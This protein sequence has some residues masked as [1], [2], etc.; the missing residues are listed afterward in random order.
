MKPELT[1]T[2]LEREPIVY[3]G[4]TWSEIK[5]CIRRAA[6]ITLPLMLAL[7][8]L[9]PGAVVLWF[10]PGLLGWLGLSY[11]L[12]QYIRKYRAGKP[13]YYERHRRRAHTPV[14]IRP[15]PIYQ[16]ERRARRSYA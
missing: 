2:E 8:A 3:F 16:T 7:M 6:L 9:A 1:L 11:R 12:T 13:L 5:G 15:Q 10:I 14:F 4:C